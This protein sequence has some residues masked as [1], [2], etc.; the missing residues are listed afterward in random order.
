MEEN[1]VTSNECQLLLDAIHSV[2]DSTEG[3]I[4]AS[5]T[6]VRSEI[7]ANATITN[8]QLKAV[9]EHLK[10]LNGKVAEHERI[11]NERT[12]IVTEFNQLKK[13]IAWMKK[14]WVPIALLSAVGVVLIVVIYDA[15]GLRGLIS[16]LVK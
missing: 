1:K 8:E 15:V 16:A 10:R 11:I 5:M 12:G 3:A 9:N 4:S 6:A 14:N 7:N 13:S 2:R